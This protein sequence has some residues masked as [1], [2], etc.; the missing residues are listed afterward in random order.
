MKLTPPK[1][2]TFWIAVILGVL[3]LLG[4]LHTIAVF[5]PYAFWLVFAGLVLLVIA[6]LVKDL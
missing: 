1:T 4:Y 6:N 2:I 3:G 5:T